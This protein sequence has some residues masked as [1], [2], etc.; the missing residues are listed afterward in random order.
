MR[1]PWGLSRGAV[2]GTNH[3]RR[4]ADAQDPELASIERLQRRVHLMQ[5]TCQP[6]ESAAR[7]TAEPRKPLPP[8]TRRRTGE[9]ITRDRRQEERRVES[10]QNEARWLQLEARAV[11]MRLEETD[12]KA[13]TK[14]RKRRSPSSRTRHSVSKDRLHSDPANLVLIKCSKGKKLYCRKLREYTPEARQTD[15]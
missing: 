7:Q 12:S 5:S 10:R 14:R 1:H 11:G 6:R 2:D 9:V 8:T 3:D 13:K 4:S 15:L